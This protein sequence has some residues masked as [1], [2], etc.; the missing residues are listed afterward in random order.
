MKGCSKPNFRVLF[1]VLMIYRHFISSCGWLNVTLI[2]IWRKKP[3]NY[4]CYTHLQVL[5]FTHIKKQWKPCSKWQ[6]CIQKLNV[7][8][9]RFFCEI[10]RENLTF[11]DKRQIL[12][13]SST[14]KY[15]LII[16]NDFCLVNE[17]LF[18]KNWYT[19]FV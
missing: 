4:S 9:A 7:R 19:N 12:L 3:M 8:F 14:E 13:D 2:L 15:I 16:I 17:S 5:L 18:L 10:S 11:G 1:M 6:K